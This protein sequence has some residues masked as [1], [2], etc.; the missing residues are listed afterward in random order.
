MAA[1]ALPDPDSALL[2]QFVGLL[3]SIFLLPFI[4]LGAR[5][6]PED[7]YRLALLD[8]GIEFAGVRVRRRRIL[9]G[10]DRFFP[11]NRSRR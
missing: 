4:L 1:V 11:H 10:L 2:I 7:R 6:E 5:L 9:S 8:R 3:G